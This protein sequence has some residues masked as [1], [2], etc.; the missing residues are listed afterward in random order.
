MS[1]TRRPMGVATALVTCAWISHAAAEVHETLEAMRVGYDTHGTLNQ[2]RD[3]AIL[4]T[5]GTSSNRSCYDD[6]IGPGRAFDTERFF[7]VTVDAIGG[8]DSS[9]PSDGLGTDFPAYTMRDMVHAQHHLLSEGL[10]VER[11]AAVAGP[12]MGGFLALEWGVQYPGY[13]DNLVVI[14]GAPYSDRLYGA[15]IDTMV[16]AMQLDHEPARS[17][18]VRMAVPLHGPRLGRE[19]AGGGLDVPLPRRPEPRHRRPLRG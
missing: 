16:E 14:A 10:G 7:V 15:M 6:Y 5:H 9:K 4:I 11:L 17:G 8:G 13:V 1:R 12:S 3:N 2:A 18:R 19:L